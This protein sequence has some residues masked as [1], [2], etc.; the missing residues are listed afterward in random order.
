ILETWLTKDISREDGARLNPAPLEEDLQIASLEWRFLAHDQR[1]RQPARVRRLKLARQDKPV[2]VFGKKFPVEREVAPARFH[3]CREAVNLD[4][5]KGRADFRRFEI[6]TNTGKHK[7]CVVRDS[8]DLNIE[9]IFHALRFCKQRRVPSPAAKQPRFVVP[10][11]S[12]QTK[13]P[14]ITGAV[15]HVR[16]IKTGRADVRTGARTRSA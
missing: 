5:T 14:S 10:V 6:V 3:V 15:D 8:A 7:L 9:A 12:V 11:I 2:A 13:H 4:E 1:K 16:T